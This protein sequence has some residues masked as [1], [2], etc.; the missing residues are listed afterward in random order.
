MAV[1]DVDA[2]LAGFPDDVRKRL[3]LVRAAVLRAAP[4]AEERISYRIPAYFLDGALIYFAGFKAHIGM[5]PITA[6]VR[7]ALA[8]ELA[9][10]AA[11]GAKASARF[12]H[13]RSIP[14]GL[15]ARI[16]KIRAHENRE[17]AAKKRAR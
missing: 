7:K 8:K 4:R 2:Y 17:R 15:I 16:V 9:A 5:Y 12:P 3:A 1:K 14:R 13:D 6:A 10:F 11:P